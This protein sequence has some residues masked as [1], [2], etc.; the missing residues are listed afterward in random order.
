MGWGRNRI[1]VEIY[2]QMG[3]YSRSEEVVGMLLGPLL[4][5]FPCQA[6]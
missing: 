5:Q 4:L 2:I 3:N 1:L 6:S